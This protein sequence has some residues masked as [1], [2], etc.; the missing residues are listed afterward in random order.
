M[1]GRLIKENGP[2]AQKLKE[3]GVVLPKPERSRKSRKSPGSVGISKKNYLSRTKRMSKSYRSYKKGSKG[4]GEEKPEKRSERER[5][6]KRCGSRCFL[7]PDTLGFPICQKLETAEDSC[8]IDC[9]GVLAAKVRA[10][11]WGYKDVAEVAD[12]IGKQSKC[13]WSN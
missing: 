10:S 13:E 9:R 8:V 4:W 5:V 12:A 2:V 6:K 3:E 7:K 11:Q 1:S